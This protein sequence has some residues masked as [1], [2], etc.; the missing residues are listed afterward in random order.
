MHI[1]YKLNTRYF[2]NDD[3]MPKEL[4]TVRE[5]KELGVYDTADFKPSTQCLKAAAMARNVI[6]NVT[7]FIRCLIHNNNNCKYNNNKLK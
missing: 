5:Q 3:S 1:G 7:L 2:I 4:E 6:D